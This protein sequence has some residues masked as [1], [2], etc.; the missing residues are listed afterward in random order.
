MSQNLIGLP[1]NN[2]LTTNSAITLTESAVEMSEEAE[3]LLLLR[4]NLLSYAVQSFIAKSDDLYKVEQHFTNKVW[5][6]IQFHW[7]Q[8]VSTNFGVLG[9]LRRLECLQI[10]IKMGK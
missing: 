3:A 10:Q 9:F 6:R 7:Y 2:L 5:G 4:E 1:P 8:Q